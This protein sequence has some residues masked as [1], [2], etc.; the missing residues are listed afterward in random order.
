[1]E[2]WRVSSLKI[3]EEWFIIHMWFCKKP[4]YLDLGRKNNEF[5]RFLF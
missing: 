1:M 2:K 5:T 4:C 3:K